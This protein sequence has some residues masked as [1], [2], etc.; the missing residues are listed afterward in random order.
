M[1]SF[2]VDE[3]LPAGLFVLY[4]FYSNGYGHILTKVGKSLL[5]LDLCLSIAQGKPFLGFNTNKCDVVYCVDESGRNEDL[6]RIKERMQKQGIKDK[7]AGNL[8]ILPEAIGLRADFALLVDEIMK[9]NP[10]TNLI[11]IDAF[12]YVRDKK[13]MRI[14]QEITLR[15]KHLTM[16]LVHDNIKISGADAD[17][18]LIL[19][20][21]E[22]TDKHVTLARIMKEVENKEYQL[23]LDTNTLKWVNLGIKDKQH[24][25]IV[26]QIAR[27]LDKVW[28]NDNSSN[29]LYSIYVFG[30][31]DKK[32]TKNKE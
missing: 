20:K 4:G 24:V 6:R 27:Y 29:K 12:G 31:E 1:K 18:V 8:I 9:E 17:G 14:L 19:N 16:L 11:C 32:T 15:Y 25:K 28:R 21:Q 22:V 3:F 2:V 5:T 30:I 10:N 7:I 23:Y 26:P 13:D